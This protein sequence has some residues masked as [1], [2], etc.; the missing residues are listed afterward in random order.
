[1][2]VFAILIAVLAGIGSASAQTGKG[3]VTLTTTP[4]PLGL[5]HNRFDATVKD[6]GGQP[7]TNAD[8]TLSLV[9]PADPKTKHPEMR[10]EGKLNNGG[11]G[12]YNGVAIVTM[13]GT[14]HVTV[15]A[16]QKGKT[17]AQS[18]TILQAHAVRPKGRK[19]PPS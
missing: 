3:S 1:M 17:I 10:T 14:W 2:R 18:K 12:K 15:T 11:G 8:V 5:G 16:A 13:A 7:V 6:A 9:M 19:R 4:S